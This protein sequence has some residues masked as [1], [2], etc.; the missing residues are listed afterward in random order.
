MFDSEMI[1]ILIHLFYSGV[2]E[3]DSAKYQVLSTEEI[4]KVCTN[5]SCPMLGLFVNYRLFSLNLLFLFYYLL[6]DIVLIL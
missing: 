4:E 5:C 1:L 2:Y 3:E 6:C